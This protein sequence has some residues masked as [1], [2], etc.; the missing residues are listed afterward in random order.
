MYFNYETIVLEF[1]INKKGCS[2]QTVATQ[3][4]HSKYTMSLVEVYRNDSNSKSSRVNY[5]EITNQSSFSVTILNYT[6]T[7]RTAYTFEQTTL[8]ALLNFSIKRNITIDIT[9]GGILCQFQGTKKFQNYRKETHIYISCKDFDTQYDWN[10]DPGISINV[11][12]ADLT[13]NSLCKNLNQKL[14]QINKTESVQVIPKQTIKPYTIQSWSVVA[15]KNQYSDMFKQNIVYLDNDFK[16]LNV[17]YSKGYLMRAINNFENLEF[18]FTIPFEDRQYLV[19]YQVAIIY[20]FKLVQILLSEY[21]Q[22]EFRMFDQFQEFTKGDKT[23][24]NFLAQFTNEIIPSQEDLQI[25]VNQPPTC[26]V[27]LS[28]QTVQAFKPQKVIT[29]CHF[30]E[31][32]PFTY[33]LRYFL[34]KQ[35]LIDFLNRTTDYSL[36][37][38]SYSSSY[39][40]QVTLPFSDGI[41]LIQAMDSKGSYLNIEKQLNV[42]KTVLN[43][44]QNKIQQQ[45]LNFQISLL[46]EIVL[47]HYDDQILYTNIQTYLRADNIDDQLLVYQ[48]IKLYKRIIQNKD[49]YSSSRLQNENLNSCFENFTKT[50]YVNITNVNISLTVTP[51]SLLEEL[52]QIMSITQKMIKKLAD[53]NEQILQKDVFLD[54]KLYQK[55]Q[56]IINSLSAILYLT[57]DIFLKIPKATIT[58]N[59]DKDQIINVAE[60]LISLIEKIAKHLNIQAKV[61]GFQLSNNG[62]ILIWQLSKN[63]KEMI[64]KQFNIERDL[65]DGLIDFVQKEQIELNYNYLNLSQKLQ[66]QLQKFFNLTILEINEKT[67]KKA[68]LKN[69]LYNDRYIDYQSAPRQYIM[70]MLQTP[71]CQEQVSQEK[72]YSYDCFNINKDGNFYKCELSTEEIDNKTVQISCKCQQLG[73]S[74]ENISYSQ[75]ENKIEDNN[76][77]L[78]EYP[79]LLF[80]GI[81]IAFSYFIYFELVSIEIKQQQTPQNSRID[82]EIVQMKFM[83]QENIRYSTIIQ[84]LQQFSKYASSSFMKYYLALMLQIQL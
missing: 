65:L 4:D 15:S 51:P 32:A 11:E 30:S 61:N 23:N 60:G 70:D 79:I 34:Q 69:H 3:G 83:N 28:D 20:N 41:L 26:L 67:L 48:T 74:Q 77:I 80:H 7:S 19:D 40:V 78:N 81:F 8:D 10:E 54:E 56:A 36:I 52:K 71:Y 12:C 59:Q 31:S 47:N 75:N 68:T 64:N 14:I 50:F 1:K 82:C 9:S 72:L 42:T 37:L 17:T 21:F 18:T 45:N 49:S 63:T 35:D 44:S 24:L 66:S 38:S 53:F 39:T 62:L 27:S 2:E 46:L 22:Q 16:L 55:K 25:N 76:L 57:D 84:E 73:I 6:L 33:Q 43:C 13:M 5:S 58:S 29:V